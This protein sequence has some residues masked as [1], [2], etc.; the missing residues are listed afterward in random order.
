MDKKVTAKECFLALLAGNAANQN[1]IVDYSYLT[2]VA[3]RAAREFNNY[4]GYE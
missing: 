3:Y 1:K 2:Q 4:Q